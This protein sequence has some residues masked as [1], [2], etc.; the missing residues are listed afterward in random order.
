MESLEK[1]SITIVFC[2]I[3]GTI[4]GGIDDSESKRFAEL[5]EYIRIKNKSDYVYFAIASTED[6][7]TVEYYENEITKYF[8]KSTIIIPKVLEI[9][10]KRDVKAISSYNYIEHLRKDFDIHS[11]YYIDDVELL[12]FMLSGLLELNEEIKDTI[13]VHSIIP[14]HGENSLKYI[15]DYLE[16]HHVNEDEFKRN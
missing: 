10:S 7:E 12:H 11:V 16:K 4:D 3:F 13:P 2:D 8:D 14:K 5:L 9:E 15:N 1:K 6:K